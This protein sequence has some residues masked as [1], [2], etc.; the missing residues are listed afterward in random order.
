M[1]EPS[2]SIDEIVSGF[3]CSF[4]NR[5]GRVPDF[6]LFRTFF[7]ADSVIGNRTEARVTIWS[8]PDFWRPRN[9]LLTGG[10]LIEFHEWETAS[11]T[12]IFDGIA[13]RH[14]SYQKEGLLD[15]L[16]YKGAGTKCFQFA[17]TPDGWRI[18]YVLWEDQE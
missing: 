6:D 11:E 15:G 3:F 13:V 8:L 18:V 5:R 7:V 9:E 14:S 2:T 1:T 10:R 12:S 17:L 16:P 4:D